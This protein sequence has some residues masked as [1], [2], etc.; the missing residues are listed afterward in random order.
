MLLVILFIKSSVLQFLPPYIKVPTYTFPSSIKFSTTELLPFWPTDSFQTNTRVPTKNRNWSF[1]WRKSMVLFTP[2][3]GF[4]PV[5]QDPTHTVPLSRGPYT[6]QR[7]Q[8]TTILT[9]L[10]I[11][12]PT[13][14]PIFL[15]IYLYSIVDP[16]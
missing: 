1:L 2:Y 10:T 3:G 5:Q 8:I 7:F 13:Y 14:L 16:Y 4:L 9:Y 12:L 15:S 11:Y 6:R